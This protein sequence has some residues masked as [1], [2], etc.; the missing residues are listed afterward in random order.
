MKIFSL[1]ILHQSYSHIVNAK[2]MIGVIDIFKKGAKEYKK[3]LK[4]SAIILMHVFARAIA[5][6]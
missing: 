5:I 4:I 2:G 3:N 1:I 6:K